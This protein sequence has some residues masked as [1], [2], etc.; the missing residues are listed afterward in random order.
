MICIDSQFFTTNFNLKVKLSV[1]KL[2]L[3]LEVS[4]GS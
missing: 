2:Q 4:K 3:K 1:A